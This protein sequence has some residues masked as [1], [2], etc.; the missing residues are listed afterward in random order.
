[1]DVYTT[2]EEQVEALKKWWREN[3]KSVIFGIVFGLAAVFGWRGWQEHRVAQAQAASELYQ[4]TLSA[5]RSDSPVKAISPAQE[6]VKNYSDTGYGVLARLVLA[7]VAVD[8]DKL[9]QAA[10]QLNQALAKTDEPTLKLEIRLRLAR[11]QV[12]QGNL[13]AALSSLT[14]D[15]PGSFAP[16]IAELRGDVLA[17]QGKAQQA[18]DAYQKA[19]SGYSEEGQDTSTLEMK[20]DELGMANQG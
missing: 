9:D 18:Y 15:K 7:K 3:G 1:L 6:I 2:E 12:A 5:L 13:D 20:I 11:V 19:R 14:V 17:R 10:E 8:D 4:D 16:A